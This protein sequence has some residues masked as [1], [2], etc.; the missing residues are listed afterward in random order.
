MDENE[1]EDNIEFSLINEIKLDETLALWHKNYRDNEGVYREDVLMPPPLYDDDLKQWIENKN[2]SCD[3]RKIDKDRLKEFYN[4]ELLI[5][6]IK[7]NEESDKRYEEF[8]KR[9]NFTRQTPQAL[10]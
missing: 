7:L 2:S 9:Y 10:Q 6:N 8:C 3:L 5:K 1:A 4:A